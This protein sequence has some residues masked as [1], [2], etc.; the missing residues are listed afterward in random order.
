MNIITNQGWLYLI[1]IF[2][3][4]VNM[5]ILMNIYPLGCLDLLR[6]VWWK[7]VSQSYLL[8]RCQCGKSIIASLENSK[9]STVIV[10]NNYYFCWNEHL[11]SGVSHYY[12]VVPMTS[13][14]FLPYPKI[15]HHEKSEIVREVCE[16]L[17]SKVEGKIHNSQSAIVSASSRLQRYP[18]NS[19]IAM[20]PPML[21]Y[22][23]D[24]TYFPRRV[25]IYIKEKKIDPS[26]ITKVPT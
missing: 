7:V 8:S 26:M 12:F 9:G 5:S 21:L 24:F 10:S 11:V 2:L 20:A 18:S 3:T 17:T 16:Q 4:S 13:R 14:T 25:L 6:K 22:A 19:Q 15:L 1:Q 23:S